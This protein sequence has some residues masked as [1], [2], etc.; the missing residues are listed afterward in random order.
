MTDTLFRAALE[1]RNDGRPPVWFMR[2]A[3]RY[4]SHYQALR[5]QHG[6]IELCKRPEL[7]CEVTMGPID[8]FDFD[9]AILFSDLLFP[10]EAMGMG[11]DYVPGPKLDWHLR[12]LDDLK[13]LQ[14]GTQNLD[15][16]A[17]Q[18]EAVTKIRAAL[19]DS[20]GLLG[21]VGGPLTLFFYAV[22]GS[23]QGDLSDSRAGLTDGRFDGFM[24]ALTDLVVENMI[25]QARAG[26][27]VV[28]VFDTCGGEVDVDVY[29]E[30]A[31]PA[32]ARILNA[33][34]AACPDVPVVYYSRGTGSEYW[35]CL[36]DLPIGCLGV[37]WRSPLPEVVT[38][39]G[40]RWA[41]QG[42]ADPDWLLL[43]RAELEA[44]LVPYF[45]G[46]LALPAE[47]RRG[48]VCGLGHGVTPKVPEENVHAFIRLQREMFA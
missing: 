47:A 2:Q 4:H 46:M 34:H 15:Q 3:G 31:V 38:A 14:G 33:Y 1:K 7:A 10:L 44:K 20:K 41:I 11:L 5:K 29:R 6:F 24:E 48:W 35:D 9:A 37:D 26:A 28:A 43:P 45:E 36:V 12:S 19:P 25:L 18:G 17:F 16:L 8:E 40:D 23:H 30:R 22:N 13:R 32:L 21:F 39:Y 42:N 27:D